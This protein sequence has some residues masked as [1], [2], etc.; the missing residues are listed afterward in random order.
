MGVLLFAAI[1]LGFQ[2]IQ[3]M[4][5]VAARELVI[6]QEFRRTKCMSFDLIQIKLVNQTKLELATA[7]DD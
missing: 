5:L 1:A 4:K 3:K 7:N 2:I 6:D